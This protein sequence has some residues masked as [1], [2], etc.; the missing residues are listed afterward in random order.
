[1]CVNKLNDEQEEAAAAWF[2]RL[3]V[4]LAS[5][6]RNLQEVKRWGFEQRRHLE[7]VEKR[8]AA[9]EAVELRTTRNPIWNEARASPQTWG[10]LDEVARSQDFLCSVCGKRMD[11]DLSLIH[12][13]EPT[14]QA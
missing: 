13:S 11:Y 9:L 12:I 10:W 2:E 7:E 6:E 1:M 14:R 5:A 3:E 8:V 4:R